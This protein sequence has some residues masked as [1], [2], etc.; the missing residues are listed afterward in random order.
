MS[1][2]QNTSIG[3]SSLLLGDTSGQDDFN[4]IGTNGRSIKI[5]GVVPSAGGGLVFPLLAT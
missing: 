3:G 5:N 1:S 2:K 4:I